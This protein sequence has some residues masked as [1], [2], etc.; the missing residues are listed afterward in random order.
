MPTAKRGAHLYP[1][2]TP[3]GGKHIV[4]RVQQMFGGIGFKMFAKTGQLDTQGPL[5]CTKHVQS[6]KFSRLPVSC[7]TVIPFDF[8]QFSRHWARITQ[9]E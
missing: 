4:Q 9:A 1:R 2:L 3:D 8:A 6:M 5:V 7:E